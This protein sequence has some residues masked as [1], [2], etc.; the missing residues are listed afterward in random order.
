MQSRIPKTLDDLKRRTYSNDE[1]LRSNID[2]EKIRKQMY[3]DLITVTR[4]NIGNE[5]DSLLHIIAWWCHERDAED[6]PFMTAAL[7]ELVR[8]GTTTPDHILSVFDGIKP[9]EIPETVKK[10]MSTIGALRVTVPD[11]DEEEEKPAKTQ[12]KNHATSKKKKRA[13]TPQ[14]SD[15]ERY[16][17]SRPKK[18]LKA[19]NDHVTIDPELAA[20]EKI[21]NG[22]LRAQA[23]IRYSLKERTAKHTQ[24]KTKTAK[25]ER[26]QLLDSD[27][28]SVTAPRPKKTMALVV[29]GKS[30]DREVKPRYEPEEDWESK[31]FA[32]E[33]REDVSTAV[34]R[35]PPRE[36]RGSCDL[37]ISGGFRTQILELVNQA[38]QGDR[39]DIQQ[40]KI[41]QA[42]DRKMLKETT[43]KVKK[44]DSMDA[45]LDVLLARFTGSDST[46]ALPA[47]GRPASGDTDKS[48]GETLSACDGQEMDPLK[49]KLTHFIF[50]DAFHTAYKE[51]RYDTCWEYLQARRKV[52]AQYRNALDAQHKTSPKGEVAAHWDKIKEL[53]KTVPPLTTGSTASTGKGKAPVESTVKSVFSDKTTEKGTAPGES[54]TKPVSSDKSAE[55][56]AA[57]ESRPMPA[58]GANA[59]PVSSV[60]EVSYSDRDRKS[61]YESE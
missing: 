6:E 50:N 34:E 33:S 19:D 31:F 9:G 5:D 58:G 2:E 32:E 17:D 35:V 48:K 38:L 57:H 11:D 43:E 12:Q 22:F 41:K 26:F 8:D 55:K 47:P 10:L 20:I 13:E 37:V 40:L 16:E 28:E 59:A 27:E 45:K 61:A 39:D 3:D 25:D 30:G 24:A 42:E 18:H 54:T 49:Y 46:G 15:D 7:S 53:S 36:E 51:E 52:V 14:T 1:K 56:G 60:P 4:Q 44:I 21:K 23:A 29:R